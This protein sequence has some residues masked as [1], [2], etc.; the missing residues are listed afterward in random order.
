MSFGEPVRSPAHL[1]S[2]GQIMEISGL[3]NKLLARPR[4]GQ[5]VPN[6]QEE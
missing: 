1:E 2:G 3:T 5:R 6:Q 4:L